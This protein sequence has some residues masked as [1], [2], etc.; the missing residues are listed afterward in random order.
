MLATSSPGAYLDYQS[1]FDQG[2]CSGL[3]DIRTFFTTGL[4]HSLRHTTLITTHDA[5]YDKRHS[6]SNEH[7][8][9][10]AKAYFWSSEHTC[11]IDRLA[12]LNEVTL[13]DP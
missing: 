9:N 13:Y 12:Q 1:L 3:R 2:G 4:R 5:H 6:F 8:G 7:R 10:E 11:I